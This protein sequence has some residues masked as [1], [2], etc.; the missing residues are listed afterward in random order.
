[1]DPLQTLQD[2]ENAVNT[3]RWSE[4][5]RLLNGYYLWRIKGG[6]RP[7]MRDMDGDAF[8]DVCADQLAEAIAFRL[9]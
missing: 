1:M 9:Q 3:G 5:I 6:F 4:A 7:N 2:L 8:A